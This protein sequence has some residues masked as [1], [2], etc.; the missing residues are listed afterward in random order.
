MLPFDFH[1]PTK[2]YFGPGKINNIGKYLQPVGKKALIVTGH[3]SMKKLGILGKVIDNLK[4]VNIDSVVF[5]GIEP[6]PRH[7]TCDKAAELAREKGCDMIVGLG[8]GSVMDAA[9]GIAVTAKT[10]HSI[11]DFV[12]TIPSRPKKKIT[13][14][15]PIICIPT[16]AATGSEADSGGV[17]TNWETHEKTGIW[18]P[19]L[20]PTVSIVDPELTISCPPDYTADGGV[21]IISHVIEGYFTGTSEAYLQDRLSE[22]VIKTVVKY[23]PRAIR[24]GADLEARNHLSWS[25]TVALSGF[26]NSGRGGSYPLHA[27]EHVVSAHYDISHGRG[28][29]LLLPALMDYTMPARPEKF[30]ELGKNVFDL[31][32]D[33]EDIE[34]AAQISIEATK[35]WLASIGRLLTFSDLGIDDSKFEIMADDL[36]RLN[37]QSQPYM[38][39]PKPIDRAGVLEI[40]RMTR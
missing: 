21:D 5:E 36:V 9:K 11:W 19:V 13:E 6:N 35:G 27:L 14:A 22:S 33:T 1:L 17:I 16:I 3:S 15:L 24:N 37:M 20:F 4:T 30:I 31:S 2:I 29:A 38:I 25:S 7:T 26:V 40:F 23:L 18:G 10:G 28:L 39:N 32:L 8:G 12:Y 34:D